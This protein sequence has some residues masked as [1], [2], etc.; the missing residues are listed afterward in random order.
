MKVGSLQ[1]L[2]QFDN[3]DANT[4][5]ME[6]DDVGNNSLANTKTKNDQSWYP[7]NS[8]VASLAMDSWIGHCPVQ[9]CNED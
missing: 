1:D 3:D 2:N 8:W 7:P 4:T 9:F 5:L 6:N